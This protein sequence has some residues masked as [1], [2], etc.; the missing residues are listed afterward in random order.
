MSRQRE[1]RIVNTASR[2]DYTTDF[3]RDCEASQREFG[4]RE[5]DDSNFS[6]AIAQSEKRGDNAVSRQRETRIV[7]TASREDYTTDFARDCEASQREFGRREIDD[8]NFSCAIAQSEKRGDNAV[9]RQRQARTVNAR[10]HEDYTTD[11]A[12]EYDASNQEF[13]QKRIRSRGRRKEEIM[14]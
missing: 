5:I 12:R 13:D 7:N 1:T 9:S 14:Q 10:S 8:S 4:R 3:A 11:Y 2:E 6:C